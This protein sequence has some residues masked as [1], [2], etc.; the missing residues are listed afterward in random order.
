M[1]DHDLSRRRAFSQIA[2]IVAIAPIAAAGVID[3]LPG[4]RARRKALLNFL[5]Q[6][7][8]EYDEYRSVYDEVYDIETA[9]RETK[10]TTIAGIRAQLTYLYD[11]LDEGYSIDNKQEFILRIAESASPPL[12]ASA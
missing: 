9:I 8:A 6:T 12:G 2:G 10:A 4:L 11:L 3:P 1:A 7:S 5:D